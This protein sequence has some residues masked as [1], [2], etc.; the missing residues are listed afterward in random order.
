LL[1]K[2]GIPISCRAKLI[3]RRPVALPKA[4]IR[5]AAIAAVRQLRR[6]PLGFRQARFRFRQ[7]GCDCIALDARPAGFIALCPKLLLEPLQFPFDKDLGLLKSCLLGGEELEG[8]VALRTER[9][10]ELLSPCL[11]SGCWE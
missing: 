9:G 5:P 10:A 8:A 7:A 4:F 3:H 6:A 2:F 11:G 1:L